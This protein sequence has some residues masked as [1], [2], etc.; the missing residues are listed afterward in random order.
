MA[1]H[2]PGH[3]TGK[4]LRDRVP[5]RVPRLSPI[6][7]P[8]ATW[9]RPH[10]TDK[11]TKVHGG[12]RSPA[13][14][15]RRARIEHRSLTGNRGQPFPAELEGTVRA[16]PGGCCRARCGRRQMARLTRSPGAPEHR[17]EKSSCFSEQATGAGGHRQASGL[18]SKVDME[19]QRWP[20]TVLTKHTGLH[21]HRAGTARCARCCRKSRTARLCTE[22]RARRTR[23]SRPARPA[24]PP[25]LSDL[26]LSGMSPAGVPPCS[27]EPSSTSPGPWWPQT[28]HGHRRGARPCSPA[29]L[30]K[31][32]TR[33]S[34]H[35]HRCPSFPA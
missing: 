20:F 19:R 15:R 26:Q 17:L 11:Q 23:P 21:H 9:H 12:R 18:L 14:G 2:P 27:P 30:C 28:L 1:R 29:A 7:P 4:G 6:C 8:R 10:P 5:P 24:L 34:Q 25:A 33:A 35:G 31:P 22:V 13:A 3:P 16:G 32:H